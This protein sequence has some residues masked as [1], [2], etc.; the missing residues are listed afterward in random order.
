ME[1]TTA[2]CQSGFLALRDKMEVRA[3]IDVSR[4]S[5]GSPRAGP[6]WHAELRSALEAMRSQLD[7][8]HGELETN[9]MKVEDQLRMGSASRGADDDAVRPLRGGVLVARE[10]F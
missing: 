10:R 6:D 2:E 8:R 4:E 7:R 9:L 1:S 3:T 5:R